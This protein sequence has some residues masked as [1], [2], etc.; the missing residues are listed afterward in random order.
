[1]MNICMFLSKL[2][3]KEDGFNSNVTMSM[4][5]TDDPSYALIS[6]LEAQISDEGLVKIVKNHLSISGKNNTIYTYK[7]VED[8]E[9]VHKNNQILVPQSKQQSVLDWYNKIL[10]HP[11]EAQM[12]ETVNLVFTWSSLNKQVK[13]LVKTWHECQIC[14]RAGK[15]KYRLL[16]PKSAE[17]IR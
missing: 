7:S 15:K 13:K 14:K 3:F 10:I 4:T 11:G 5:E 9:L 6:M 16:P 17:S 1:M 8:V 2:E 12:I